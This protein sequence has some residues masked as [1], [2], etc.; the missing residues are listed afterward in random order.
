[1]VKHRKNSKRRKKR[2]RFGGA[3]ECVNS[4]N[5]LMNVDSD[6]DGERDSYSQW[7]SKRKSVIQPAKGMCV[8]GK[9]YGQD[10]MI[11]LIKQKGTGDPKSIR[12]GGS[13][14]V[15]L[16]L[17][18][19]QRIKKLFDSSPDQGGGSRRRRRR[20][21]TRR[22]KIRRRRRRRRRTRHHKIRRRRTRRRRK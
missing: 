14:G 21:S 4:T 19:E 10:S 12:F 5:A 16:G 15:N 20:R 8:M 3:G 13:Q 22:R 1:M 9:C 17:V 11:N 18:T 6:C 7:S 2:L